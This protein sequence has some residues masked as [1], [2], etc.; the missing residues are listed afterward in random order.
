MSIKKTKKAFREYL[1]E[2]CKDVKWKHNQFHQRTRKYGDYLYCQDLVMFNVLYREWLE[3][4]ENEEN[5]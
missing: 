3:N 4:L 2:K 5:K 1:N